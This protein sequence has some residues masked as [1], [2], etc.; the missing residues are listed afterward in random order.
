MPPPT[1]LHFLRRIVRL[2]REAGTASGEMMSAMRFVHTEIGSNTVKHILWLHPSTLGV[3]S[4]RSGRAIFCHGAKTIIGLQKS[5]ND[6]HRW[7]PLI[8][9]S[10]LPATIFLR[11]TTLRTMKLDARGGPE[12]C[13]NWHLDFESLRLRGREIQRRNAKASSDVNRQAV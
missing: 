12:I 9:P 11:R 6:R 13:T 7:F 2:S 5:D 4:E 8:D 3:R 1:T 10:T